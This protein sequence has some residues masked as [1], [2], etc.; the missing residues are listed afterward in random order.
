MFILTAN[1]AC[2]VINVDLCYIAQVNV[3]L[4]PVF[5]IQI[6]ALNSTQLSKFIIL[7]SAWPAC[8]I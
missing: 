2:H 7:I 3:S 6:I 8:S 5:N 4:L 1:S